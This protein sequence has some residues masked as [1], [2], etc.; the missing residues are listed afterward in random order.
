MKKAMSMLRMLIKPL[1]NQRGQIG[2][3][4]PDPNSVEFD[5]NGF[6]KGTN[7][8]TVS[9]FIKGYAELKGAYD[10][11]QN[12]LGQVRTQA[13]TLAEAY[14][15]L[16]SNKGGGVKGDQAPTE[17]KSAEYDKMA[18]KAQ[19][20]LE[21]LDPMDDAFA[22]KQAKLV[23]DL[24]K[25]TAMSQHEKT[26]GAAR[27]FF[28]E[29]LTKRDTMAAQK[30]FLDRYPD[31]N[32]PEMQT[33]IKDFLAKDDTGMHDNM[34][35]FFEIRATD[36]AQAAQTAAKERDDIKE[37]LRLQ[38][39]KDSTGK[40]IPKGQPPGQPS[41]QA[42]LTGKDADAGALEALRSVTG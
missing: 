15:E 19:A 22:A 7:Y 13:A 29:E 8:K 26:L 25:F 37:I 17:D 2:S 27:G 6:I 42:R 5:D 4:E 31:Y 41:N 33:R 38:H 12:E 18:A 35:A 21:K 1:L 34:S 39:G 3:E 9:D 24:T 14:K 32:T 16:A 28:K 36:N 11:G 40:V 10:K 30:K 23:A 20:D